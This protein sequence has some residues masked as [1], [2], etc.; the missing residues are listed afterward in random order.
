[1]KRRNPEHWL[2]FAS[3]IKSGRHADCG[4]AR[5]AVW[6]LDLKRGLELL[7]CQNFLIIL[8]IPFQKLRSVQPIRTFFLT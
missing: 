6:F 2:I 5:A 3:D 4:S 8:I 1:M 7:S